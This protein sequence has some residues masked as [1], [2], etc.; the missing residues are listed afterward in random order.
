[1]DFGIAKLLDESAQAVL[2]DGFV[3]HTRVHDRLLTP[4]YASPEQIRGQPVM[5]TSDVY[6]L[7]I[8][9]YELLTGVRPYTVNAHN[10]LELERSICIQDPIKPSQMAI[11][12]SKDSTSTTPLVKDA[13]LIP[14]ARKTTFAK[15]ETQLKGD[16]DAIVMKALRKEPEHRYSSVEHLIED[17]KRHLT[18]EPVEAR[19]GTQWYYTQR[20][21]RRHTLGVIS[22][23]TALLSLIAVAIVLSVQANRLKEQRDIANQQREIAARALVTATQERAQSDA[24]AN[25]MAEIFEGADPYSNPNKHLTGVDLLDRAALRLKSQRDLQPVLK[26]TLFAKIGYAY[27]NIGTTAQSIPYLEQ[28]LELRRKI[29]EQDYNEFA[30]ILIF[31]SRAYLESGNSSKAREALQEARRRLEEYGQQSPAVYHQALIQSSYVERVTGQSDQ[32]AKFLDSSLAFANKN[33]GSNSIEAADSAIYLAQLRISQQKFK[34]AK[35][36]AIAANKIYAKEYPINHADRVQAEIT[37]GVCDIFTNQLLEG[38]ERIRIGLAKQKAIFGNNNAHLISTYMY[39]SKALRAQ[40]KTSAAVNAIEEAIKIAN[41]QY[42]PKSEL[43]AMLRVEQAM[44][45][46]AKHSYDAA[47]RNVSDA[48]NALESIGS[49]ESLN[50]LIAKNLQAKLLAVLGNKKLA[51]NIL[52]GN[53]KISN[54]YLPVTQLALT[55]SL[56]GGLL[57]LSPATFNEGKYLL[58]Y[59]NDLITTTSS[60]D[61][62]PTDI[63]EISRRYKQFK[64]CEAEHRLNDCELEI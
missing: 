41:T 40:G 46:T 62:L 63:D 18:K 47:Y 55:N 51:I 2:Q 61:A 32:A 30:N 24:V 20:F 43:M 13:N 22:A 38:E 57:V 14:T 10:Q 50:Y 1:L 49:V 31:L 64:R 15:L 44:V 7:G 12:L 45:N 35:E 17:I 52:R 36:L 21:I 26:A 23:T 19:Q 60:G 5:T 37:I 33:F 54:A 56:L 42:G 11:A 6:A 39:L 25:F 28:A 8:I 53:L 29:K 58:S 48:I 34:A 59:S 4:E 3:A 16:L 9:L 27:A